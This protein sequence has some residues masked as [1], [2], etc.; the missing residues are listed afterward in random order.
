MLRLKCVD[1]LI[2]GAGWTSQFLIPLLQS[3]SISFAATTTT[4]H[5]STIPFK[6]DPDSTDSTPY[7][8]L[9]A[10][11]AV[12]ITFP[13]KGPGQSQLLTSLYRSVHGGANFWIQ[14]GSTGIFSA[15]HWNDHTSPYDAGNARAVAEDELRACVGGCVLNLAGLYGGERDPKDWVVRVARTK[16]QVR[17]KWALHLVHGADVARA[18]VGVYWKRKE[19]AMRGTRWLVTDLRVYDWWD[20]IQDWGPEVQRR[21]AGPE[22]EEKAQGLEYTRW[23]GELMVEGGVR[24]LPRG[25][26]VL[27]RVLDSRAFW[28]EIGNWPGQ[29]RVK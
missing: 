12:L 28:E 21:V 23:V 10:A 17:G 2:L 5:D 11:T 24:S 29:G 20:L 13:L 19:E 9:P 4:G 3:S 27:G 22:G 25:P 8:H 6:F 26:E 7:T 1:L 16:E 18:V 15:P 14:L